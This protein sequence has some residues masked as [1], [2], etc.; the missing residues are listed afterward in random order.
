[1][2]EHGTG[3]N[4]TGGNGTGGNGTGGSAE[5]DRNG[6]RVLL[7][8]GASSGIGEA[9]ARAAA[10]EGWRVVL[11]ARSSERLA[12]LVEELGEA[13]ALAIPLDVT[14]YAAQER[15]VATALERFDRLDAVFANAGTGGQPGGFSGAPVES[16]KTMLDVNVFGAACT[17]RASLEALKASRGARAADRL[18]RRT[19]HA[20]GLDVLGHQVGGLG[21]RLRASRGAARHRRARHPD[22]AGHG[23]H[24]PFFDSEKPD[25]LRPDDIARSA[26]YALSQP[27]SVDVHEILVL[28]TPPLEDA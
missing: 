24:P 7:I 18:G 5:A 14:D 1:M 12:A 21:D 26:V 13:N 25:A 4:G 16:W 17:L 20:R 10:A 9:T 8:T 2:S 15:M 23:R 22:R 19:A 6:G 3:G 28:P 11:A 27:P